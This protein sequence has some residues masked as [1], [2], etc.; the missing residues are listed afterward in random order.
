MPFSKFD[1]H[2]PPGPED[3]DPLRPATPAAG[4]RARMLR[5]AN[6]VSLGMLVLGYGLIAYWLLT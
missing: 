3:L 6:L 2:R 1:P 4:R 5:W